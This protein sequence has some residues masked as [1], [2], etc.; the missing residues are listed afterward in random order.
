[1]AEEYFKIISD[2]GHGLGGSCPWRSNPCNESITTVRFISLKREQ[3]LVQERLYT[4]KEV[5]STRVFMGE[6]EA[7]EKLL[8]VARTFFGKD[9]DYPIGIL[10]LAL[11]QWQ[12][13]GKS[14]NCS[15]G[16]C[17]LPLEEVLNNPDGF[18][19]IASHS[20]FCPFVY[21]PEPAW[22]A[23]IDLWLTKKSPYSNVMGGEAKG[24]IPSL[25]PL[26]SNFTCNAIYQV[27]GDDLY[28]S[29]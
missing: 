23:L 18:D 29:K 10:L 21:G 15:L 7:F 2:K 27:L 11:M 16:C 26:L 4:F 28:S 22:K 8:L 3:D 1:M 12:L 5:K 20:Y 17:E 25:D 24:A 13:H 19:T 14:V 6:E 9:D